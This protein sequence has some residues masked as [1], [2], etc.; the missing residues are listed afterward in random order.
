MIFP[1]IRQINATQFA[2][3]L[4]G[5]CQ[6]FFGGL[7]KLNQIFSNYTIPAQTMSN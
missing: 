3:A 1:P 4:R 2:G 7:P 6:G 5:V